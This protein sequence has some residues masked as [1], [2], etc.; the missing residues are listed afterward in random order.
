MNTVL[1]KQPKFSKNVKTFN[2][3]GTASITKVLTGHNNLN[4][5]AHRAKLAGNPHCEYCKEPD[6]KE[7]VLHI[8]TN[9]IT[10]SKMRHDSFGLSP[11]EFKT[12]STSQN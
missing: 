9:C 3:E 11:F 4:K 2:K 1:E 6:E 12:S 7:T 5:H 10:F 8:L